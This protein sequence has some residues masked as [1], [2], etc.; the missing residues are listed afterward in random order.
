MKLLQFFAL[1]LIFISVNSFATDSTS[2]KDYKNVVQNEVASYEQYLKEIKDFEASTK[3]NR[4]LLTEELPL[5]MNY[6]DEKAPIK[7]VEYASLS[8]IHCKQ[9]HK[10]VFYDLKKNYIDT[11]KVYFKYR[12]YPLNAPAVKGA[13][14]L[15]CVAPDNKLA[16]IGA[17]FESQTQWAYTKSEADLKEKLSTVSK[18]AGLSSEQFEACYAN[19]DKQG[20]VLT[21]MK[22]AYDELFITST[23]GIFID[24]KRF[25]ESREYGTIAKHIDGLIAA[26]GEA[27]KVE[28]KLPAV[29]TKKE[30]K[31][32]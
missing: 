32:Q 25:M 6:G 1:P 22:R 7:I 19:E 14:V 18:I 24:G 23:P 28:P 5:D 12:H 29:E 31:K 20:K 10:D 16:F 4:G 13:I 8:C 17:L 21:N 26:R 15:D 3:F 27:K 9:F 2:V 30:E 11:G